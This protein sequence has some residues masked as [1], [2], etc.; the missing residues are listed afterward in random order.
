MKFFKRLVGVI[1]LILGGVGT[2]ACLGVFVGIWVVRARTDT[3]I[4]NV[5]ERVDMALSTL[6]DRGQ[7]ANERIENIRNSVRIL[8]DRVQQR[9]ADLRGVPT[10]EAPDIDEIER[11]LYARIQLGKD[12]I[13]FVKTGVDLVEQVLQMLNSTSLFLQEE[14]KTRADLLAAMRSGHERIDE[15]F[16]LADEVRTH[17][18]SIRAHRDL[19]ESARQIQTLSSRID[20]LLDNVQ[21]YGEDFEAAVVQLRTDAANLGTR[22]RRQLL[23]VAVIASLILIWFAA[24]QIS[25]TIHGWHLLRSR[26]CVRDSTL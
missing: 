17:V 19:D 7:Q 11:Q 18:E 13:G 16:S 24:S 21:H 26:A 20:T 8:N 10:E 22:I 5:T 3:M 6:E 4:V 25:L 15:A 9:A 2:L 1:V 12:W 14:S 23:V